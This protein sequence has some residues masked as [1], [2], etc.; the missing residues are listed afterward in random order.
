MSTVPTQRKIIQGEF[1][2]GAM[3]KDDLDMLAEMHRLHILEYEAKPNNEGWYGYGVMVKNVRRH[4]DR[5]QR[6]SQPT[7]TR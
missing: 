7:H 4:T 1:R 3:S 2:F 6:W 5:K